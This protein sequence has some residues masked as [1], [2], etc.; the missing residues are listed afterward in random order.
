MKKAI[1]LC[2]LL[3]ALALAFSVLAITVL[4]D[5][6]VTP[7]CTLTSVNVAPLAESTSTSKSW[8]ATEGHVALNDGHVTTFAPSGNDCRWGDFKRYLTFDQ[9]YDFTS[10]KITT[11]GVVARHPTSKKIT[12]DISGKYIKYEFAVTLYNELDMPVYNAQYE[13]EEDGVTEINFPNPVSAYKLEIQHLDNTYI[14]TQAIY[15]VEMFAD[16]GH[17]WQ[18]V[19]KTKDPTCTVVGTCELACKNC[20]KTLTSVIPATGHTANPNNPCDAKCIVCQVDDTV[21]KAHN[22]SDNCAD[23]ECNTEG[24][25]GTRQE[26]ELPHEW[27]K[28]NDTTEACQGCSITRC[29]HQYD[30]DCDRICNIC[31]E[32][33]YSRDAPGVI[34]DVWHLLDDTCT[35]TVCNHC[36]ETVEPPH[37]YEFVCSIECLEC[38]HIRDLDDSAHTYG[39][40]YDDEN[41]VYIDET[42]E[43]CDSTCNICE[44]SRVA[45]HNL[46][47]AC[48]PMC[49]DCFSI[50]TNASRN[51]TWDN[52]CDTTCNTEGCKFVRIISHKY[53]NV[54][55]AICNVC[56]AI[57]T[58][59]TDSTFDPD[60]EYDNACDTT[61]NICNVPRLVEPHK[62]DN[63][64]DNTCNICGAVR[65]AT[66]DPSYDPDHEYDNACDTKCNTCQEERTVGP[67]SYD[68]ECDDN[69]NSCGA[70]RT[71]GAHAFGPWIEIVAPERKTEG[72]QIRNCTICNKQEDMTIPAL[73]GIGAGAVV[74][75]VSGS[76]VVAGAGGF[77]IFWFVIKKKSWADLIGVFKK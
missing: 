58:A 54:C 13:T 39:P 36:G 29:I 21:V 48:A 9:I 70:V 25:N 27:A 12:D 66:S 67:H 77:S 19:E 15:E 59:E 61:C 23:L 46:P 52:A 14:Y 32:P 51:H 57:R 64:C 18:F 71:I 44:A 72:K 47:Y 11:G 26:W 10:I 7:D 60:H 6:P 55:D 34:P 56:E 31:G 22:Y 3:L 33:K 53:D 69:C 65:T 43:L 50:N 24:C 37:V 8:I 49:L 28:V 42:K 20:T 17:E 40:I 38:D 35:D 16:V 4:A 74:G 5:D 45:P 73:G 76:V 2:T 30:N 41:D 68:N 1:K 62:Y 75:I 63:A